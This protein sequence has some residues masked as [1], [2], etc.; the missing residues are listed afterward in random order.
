M[1]IKMRH[2]N[3]LGVAG[4]SLCLLLLGGCVFMPVT[5]AATTDYDHSYNFSHVRK[6]AIQPISRDSVSTVTVSDMQI[7]RIDQALIAELQ[8]RGFQVVTVNADADMFLSW[9][10]VMQESAHVRTADGSTQ[11]AKKGTLFVN[12][13]DPVMLK[14]VWRA[15]FESGLRENPE[16]DAAAQYRQQAAE[17]ILAQFPPAQA[18][19]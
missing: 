14:S 4:L 6:I 7:G 8:R 3:Y 15:R 18:A 11:Y 9:Q 17:V 16:S 1:E 5:P 19:R 13:I 2:Y 12:M 10:L